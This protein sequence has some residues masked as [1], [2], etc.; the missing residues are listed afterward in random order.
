MSEEKIILRDYSKVVFYYPLFVLSAVGWSAQ[1]YWE[2]LAKYLDVAYLIVSFICTFTIAFDFKPQ[3]FIIFILLITTV[4]LIVYIVTAPYGIFGYVA[5]TGFQLKIL[6]S[7]HWYII[8]TGC[9]GFLLAI[10]L[11]NPLLD[12]Y[13]I[14]QNEIYHRKGLIPEKERYSVE[15]L[16]ISYGYRDAMEFILMRT[17]WIKFYLNSG[18]TIQLNTVP[19][20]R[21]K[22][23]EI[24]V[25]LSKVKVEASA[26]SLLT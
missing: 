14:E 10:A 18:E 19:F 26:N 1:L 25:L 3:K 11:L 21:Q 4:A 23:K 2:N 22:T 20:L 5:S 24:D 16:K 8:S 15:L 6:L 13:V 12:Y 7:T 17:G 9:L